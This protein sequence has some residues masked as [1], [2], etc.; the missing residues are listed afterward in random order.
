MESRYNMVDQGQSFQPV[1]ANLIATE[2]ALADDRV[3][4]E[5]LRMLPYSTPPAK[6]ILTYGRAGWRKEAGLSSTAL[7][8]GDTAS[9]SVK[10]MPFRAVIGSQ[11]NSTQTEAMRGQRSGYLI[12]SSTDYT[13]VPIA[14][15]VSGNPRQ[16]L[17]YASVTPATN[18]AT[19]VRYVKSLSSGAV[20]YTHLTL[21]T[22]REV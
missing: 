4:W 13:V 2:A 15:N 5:L 10:V 7:V 3:L 1:D 18:G 6:G 11:D 20:S 17:I 12:G 8:Q 21:P 9:G 19:A 22:N 16:T 14:A